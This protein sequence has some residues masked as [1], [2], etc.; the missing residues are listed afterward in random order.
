MRADLAVQIERAAEHVRR[1]TANVEP[2]A[3]GHAFL[4]GYVTVRLKNGS[5]RRHKACLASV[6]AADLDA[7]VRL[8]ESV[9][10]VDSVWYN[11][12]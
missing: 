2:Y 10:G 1:L 6:C 3:L 5:T 4:W 7:C 9:P 8:A 12:D 11:L